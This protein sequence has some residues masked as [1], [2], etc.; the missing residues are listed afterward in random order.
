MVV[1]ASADRDGWEE[2]GWWGWCGHRPQIADRLCLWAQGDGPLEAIIPSTEEG[3][4]GAPGS[5]DHRWG[6]GL[7]SSHTDEAPRCPGDKGAPHG[8]RGS[9]GRA[10]T[11]CSGIKN[12]HLLDSRWIRP[13]PLPTVRTQHPSGSHLPTPPS[14]L[15]QTPLSPPCG[16][17]RQQLQE[18]WGRGMDPPNLWEEKDH[19]QLQDMR[20]NCQMPM[21]SANKIRNT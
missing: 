3:Q 13:N 9:P 15:P 14:L 7:T 4:Q 17:P 18:P 12:H 2:K 6:G 20:P 16:N 5:R 8:H 19:L 21:K 1:A 10:H 11:R